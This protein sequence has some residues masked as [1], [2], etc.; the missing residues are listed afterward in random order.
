MD[1]NIS[2]IF[3]DFI[4]ELQKQIN[5]QKEA[6]VDIDNSGDVPWTEIVK[7]AFC[8]MGKAK[9]G[10]NVY[11][12][13]H[14][15]EYL[16]DVLWDST[17]NRNHGPILGVESE[18]GNIEDVVEDFYK[19]MYVKCRF[20]VLVYSSTSESNKLDL[21][22][23]IK[24]G[25]VNFNQHLVGDEYLFIDMNNCALWRIVASRF[26]VTELVLKERKTIELLNICSVEWSDKTKNYIY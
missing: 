16:L 21:E 7:E 26:T 22:Q 17:E 14:G 8:E 1:L 2:Q 19:L 9:E 10:I 24:D 13:G 3:K 11:S 6:G 12:T 25:L 4:I 15:G 18:W 20:K 23:M 5:I